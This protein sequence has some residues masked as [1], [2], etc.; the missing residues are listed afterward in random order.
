VTWNGASTAVLLADALN[1]PDPVRSL[2]IA[3]A[4]GR[5]AA[6]EVLAAMQGQA[7]S[8][9]AA[10]RTLPRDTAS[11]IG[12]ERELARLLAPPAQCHIE[13]RDRSRG[14]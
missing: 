10:T 3:A 5:V 12:R 14:V 1:L 11:F 2:F 13:E 7:T 4:L 8:P 9:A 6:A